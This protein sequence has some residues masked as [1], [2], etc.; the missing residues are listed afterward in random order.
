[1]TQLHMDLDKPKEAQTIVDE[2]LAR[3]PKLA[4]LP[5]Y[6]WRNNRRGSGYGWP[7]GSC[8]TRTSTPTWLTRA[9]GL[10]I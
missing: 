2:I 4:A 8:S 5:R 10:A 7:S 6:G 3:Y 9:A 1:M